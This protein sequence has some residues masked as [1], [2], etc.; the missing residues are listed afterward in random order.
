MEAEL[1]RRGLGSSGQVL[2]RSTEASLIPSGEELS[3]SMS[4][5]YLTSDSQGYEKSSL[6]AFVFFAIVLLAKR[7]DCC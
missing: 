6:A 2:D 4:S 1:S 7:S 3:D 5:S